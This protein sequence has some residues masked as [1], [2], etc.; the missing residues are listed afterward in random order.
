MVTQLKLKLASSRGPSEISSTLTTH[1][2]TPV[3]DVIPRVN[4]PRNMMQEQFTTAFMGN[5]HHKRHGWWD[6]PRNP[7]EGKLFDRFV[8]FGNCTLTRGYIGTSL[9]VTSQIAIAVPLGLSAFL[10]FCILRTKWSHFYM[11]LLR[12]RGMSRND[13][14]LAAR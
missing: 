12:Q 6:D 10:T 13:N 9:Y 7:I 14:F 1:R 8:Y 4:I 3:S 5:E 11:A 2:H